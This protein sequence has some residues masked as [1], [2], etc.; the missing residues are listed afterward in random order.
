VTGVDEE[1]TSLFFQL[2]LKGLS[3]IGNNPLE[4]LRQNIGGYTRSPTPSAPGG[5]YFPGMEA[6]Q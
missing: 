5:A 4:L 1:S 6:E 2:E 3:R